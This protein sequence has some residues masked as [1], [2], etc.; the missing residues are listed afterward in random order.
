MANPRRLVLVFAH[1][2][3]HCAPL[4]LEQ[5]PKLAARLGVPLRLLDIDVPHEEAEADRIVKEHGDW[6]PDYL[7]PQVF[8]ELDNGAVQHLLTG[9][10][11]SVAATA[12]SWSGLLERYRPPSTG[13]P[14][15]S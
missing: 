12:R 5:A 8:L 14:R 10:P 15:T 9:T 7:I 6:D 2:C 13:P 3:P 4:S 11:G 1:W